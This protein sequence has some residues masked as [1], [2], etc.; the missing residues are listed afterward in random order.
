MLGKADVIVCSGFVGNVV[1]KMLEGFYELHQKMFGKIDTPAGRKFDEMWTT[2]VPRAAPFS[3][4]SKALASSLT[5]FRRES[6]RTG[7]Q[8]SLSVR[9]HS[10]SGKGR[11]ETRLRNQNKE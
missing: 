9:V 8:G 2:T 1:L 5:P 11:G 6:D 3:S 4:G 10:D 7:R